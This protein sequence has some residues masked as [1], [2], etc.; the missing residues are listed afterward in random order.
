MQTYYEMEASTVKV[1]EKA[2]LF[3]TKYRDTLLDAHRIEK[4]LTNDNIKIKLIDGK[5]NV[6]KKLQLGKSQWN[7]KMFDHFFT[8]MHPF[9]FNTEKIQASKN[10]FSLVEYFEKQM[11]IEMF[12]EKGRALKESIIF[13]LNEILS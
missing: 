7:E 12:E 8:L 3:Y 4:K 6:L 2:K 13:L 10:L 1:N 5:N 9:T 11:T